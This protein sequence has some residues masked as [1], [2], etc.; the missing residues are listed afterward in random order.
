MAPSKL[1][2]PSRS[3]SLYLL[4]PHAGP[5]QANSALRANHKMAPPTP[6]MFLTNTLLLYP[7]IIVPTFEKRKICLDS[8]LTIWLKER[9]LQQW[10]LDL[11][12]IVSKFGAPLRF[13]P[14]AA[15]Q[16]ALPSVRP[17]WMQSNPLIPI[18]IRLMW[19]ESPVWLWLFFIESVK[20]IFILKCLS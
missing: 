12:I 20:N 18:T 14:Q 7:E 17:W 10:T 8:F 6:L 1:H 19:L 5:Y 3:L 9:S 11:F 4:L 15:A 2:L 13:A 16:L